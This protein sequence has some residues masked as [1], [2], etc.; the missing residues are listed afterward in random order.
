MNLPELESFFRDSN[1][2][3]VT[4][5]QHPAEG[6]QLGVR[7]HPG[8]PLHLPE[9][10]KADSYRIVRGATISDALDAMAALAPAVSDS[11]SD[12]VFG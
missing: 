3:T 7:A 9:A 2:G 10:E 5:L 8:S 1:I 12:D 6:W 4:I 11:S